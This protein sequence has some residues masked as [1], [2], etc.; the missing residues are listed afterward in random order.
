MSLSIPA[1]TLNGTNSVTNFCTCE[2]S[3]ALQCL[4]Q[5]PPGFGKK[6]HYL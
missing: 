1:A 6:E 5:L 3:G 4:T 2:T